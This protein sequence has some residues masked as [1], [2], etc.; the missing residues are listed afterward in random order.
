[1]KKTHSKQDFRIITE[2]QHTVN[3]ST[4]QLTQINTSYNSH[5]FFIFF[6]FF[7]CSTSEFVE[8]IYYVDI[9]TYSIYINK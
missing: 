3:N 6:F 7:E 2:N 1:M 4:K 9:Y 8:S 5:H